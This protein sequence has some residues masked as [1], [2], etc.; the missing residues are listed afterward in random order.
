MS[1]KYLE[2]IMNLKLLEMDKSDRI[3]KAMK[4]EMISTKR[5][6]DMVRLNEKIVKATKLFEEDEDVSSFLKHVM[7]K[8]QSRL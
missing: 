4:G 2:L 6:Q 1:S 8:T 5:N 3:S 7:V